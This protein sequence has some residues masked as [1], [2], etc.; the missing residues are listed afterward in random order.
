MG[1]SQEHIVM[2]PFM[3]QGHIIPFLALARQ[4]HQRTGFNITIANTPLNIQK[5]Q[6]TVAKDTSSPSSQSPI[7]LVALPFNSADHGLP[8]GRESTESL[9]LQ[10]IITLFHASATLEAPC[11]R[12]ISDIADKEGRPPLCIISDVFFGWATNVAK[13]TGTVN[14]SF[15]TGGAYGTAAYVSMWQNLP[16]RF[17]ECD[18]FCLPGF[19]DSCRFHISQLHR[20]L[21]AADGTDAWSTFFQPQI[22]LSLRSYGWLC[23]AVEEIEPL[24]LDIL[25]KYVK[26]PVW[27]IG[28]LLPPS[29]LNPSSSSS[30]VSSQRAG[31]D[32]GSS[33]EKCLEW[34][35]LH[36][37]GSVLYIS[38]GS[39]NTISPSQM[40]ELA[41]GLEDSGVA[42]IWVI[43]PPIGFDLKGE[44]RAEWLPEGFEERMVESKR[45]LLVHNWAPQVEILSHK[46]T[47][48]FISHCGW[49]STMESLSQGVPIIGWPLAAEQAYNSK[50][51]ME[52]MGVSIELTRGVE[53]TIVKE[54]VKRVIE[55][56]MN[57]KGKG[58]EMKKKS[59]EIGELIRA[60]V[61]E[62]GGH[63]GSS[64]QAMDDFISTLLSL[65]Q[66]KAYQRVAVVALLLVAIGSNV[67][68][69]QN[70]CN[71]TGEDLMAC[72]P[73]VTPPNPTLPSAKCCSALSH[74]DLPC[75]CSYRKSKL[76][77]SLG[78]DPNLALQLPDK[79]KIPHPAHC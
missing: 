8:P 76:L 3:A 66:T 25:R 2:L 40:M 53:S 22:S 75:L 33:P 60:A 64:L 59:V 43:R 65:Q 67:C 73:S 31:R 4:I 69:A 35:D 79:C 30:N 24:G 6:S 20:F 52:E 37:Q 27:A 46:S 5:L 54:E 62:E 56:V 14:V 9:P 68:H 21:R 47:G 44:F 34:L 1:G 7:N 74:A 17:T 11:R 10:Q 38:F 61:R 51:L 36:P 72:K 78:I 39:Q 63:K 18:D 45:G 77:P 32:P 58:G 23:N 29:I 26:L 55:L 70:I 15:S 12:L 42:F 57:R 41:K 16:H 28:P 19:P 50:M 71:M 49:N 48:A 13:I